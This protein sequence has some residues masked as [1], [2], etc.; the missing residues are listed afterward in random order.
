MV[1]RVG[2]ERV[3]TKKVDFIPSWLVDFK[4]T[5]ATEGRP[6]S[7]GRLN[8]RNKRKGGRDIEVDIACMF[9]CSKC[10]LLF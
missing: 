4:L 1:I 5:S 3:K 2:F 9:M 7:S 8:F 6:T 10:H